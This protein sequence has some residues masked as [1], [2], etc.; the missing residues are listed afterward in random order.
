MMQRTPTIGRWRRCIIGNA[1]MKRTSRSLVVARVVALV[2]GALCAVVLTACEKTNAVYCCTDL[3]T[4]HEPGGSEELIACTDPARPYCDN[5]GQYGDKRT[6]IEDPT[7]GCSGP[8]DCTTP[9]APVCDVGGTGTCVGCGVMADCGRFPATPQCEPASGACVECLA[10]GDCTSASEPVCGMDHVCRACMA[11]AE[12][13]SGVCDEGTGA[14]VAEAAIVYV[15]TNGGGAVCTRAMPCATITAGIAA[16]DATRRTILVAPGSYTDRV[17]IAAKSFALVGHGA[18]VSASTAGEVIDVNAGSIAVTIEGLRVHDGLGAVGTA[19]RCRDSGGTPTL[20]L[21][22]VT[23]DRNGGAGID[24]TRCNVTVTGGTISGNN[25]AGISAN[26]A[27]LTVEASRILDNNGGGVVTSGG[28]MISIRNSFIA[29]NGDLSGAVGGVRLVEPTSLVFEFN[30]LADN[31]TMAGFA[32]GMQCSSLMPRTLSNNIIVGPSSDQV[33]SA[34][35][36]TFTYTL[37]NETIAGTGNATTAPTFVNAATNDYHLTAAS[38]G[39]D[40]AD[41]AATLATDIDGQS[42][43]QGPRADIG[44]D[45]VR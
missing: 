43:P 2:A 31:G 12:C 15:A 22:G 4:C 23:L 20:T 34:A 25:G 38:A 13:A 8:E 21:V 45:E 27:T 5:D 37:S 11:D 7:A 40:A 1:M 28:G 10:A 17:T 16:V 42:R 44:A 32:A 41:P 18:A 19:I 26:T 39:I 3:A 33:S 29:K 36:C 9:A 30:T 14:C 6:C 24:A 35:N